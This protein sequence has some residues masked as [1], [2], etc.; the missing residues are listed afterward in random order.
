VVDNTG[1][2]GR[3]QILQQHPKV[4]CDTAHNKEGLTYVMKQL[5]NEPFKTLH[6]VFGVVN[7]KDVTAILP[8]LPKKATYYFCK[9]EIP[10]GLDANE[11]KQ[12]CIDFGFSGQAYSSVKEAYKEAMNSANE[13][14]CIY[15][16]G[17]T[18]VVAEIV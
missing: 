13:A 3:W 10:R 4:I 17:S 8:L 11:L 12:T 9:P 1:L 6:I 15:I 7:D 5:L 2:M 14:D 18:F 16:G